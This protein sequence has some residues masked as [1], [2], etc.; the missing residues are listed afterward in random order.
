LKQIALMTSLLFVSNCGFH[1]RGTHNLEMADFESIHIEVRNETGEMRQLL[2]RSFLQTNVEVLSSASK[3]EYSLLVYNERNSRRAVATTSNISV[4]EYE[5]VQQLSLQLLSNDRKLLI[6]RVTIST[7]R[8]YTFDDQSL[9]SSTEEEALLR[10]EM[11]RD[12]SEQVFRRVNASIRA[13][14]SQME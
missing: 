10:E 1:L 3:A 8:T 13:H 5:I 7:E 2:E 11:R 12:L 6:P 9:E 14:Q 4:A